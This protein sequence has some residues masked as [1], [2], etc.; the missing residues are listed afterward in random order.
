MHDSASLILKKICLHVFRDC[1]PVYFI[2]DHL[3]K[4]LK[5]DGNFSDLNMSEPEKESHIADVLIFM[6]GLLPLEDQS[7]ELSCIKM[8]SGA[9]VDAFV[10][11]INT[12]Y[13]VIIWDAAKK[14]AFLTQTQQEYNE[15]SLLIEKQKNRIINFSDKKFQK[16]NNIALEDFCRALNLAVFKMNDKG[17]FVPMGK[18]PLWLKKIS[19][20]RDVFP[21]QAYEEDDFSFIGNFINEA[22]SRWAGN[23]FETFHSGIWIEK[24]DNDREFL[25]EATAVNINGKK[26]LVISHDICHP[27]E[28]QSI[29]QKGR[30]LAIDYHH[31]QRS[32]EKLE[33]MRDELELIVKERTKSLEKLNKKLANELKERKKIEKDRE[34][35]A[36]QLRQSQ[37]MEAIGTLAGG[38]AHDFNNILSGIIGFT[39]LCRLDAQ[40]NPDLNQKLAKILTASDRAKELIRQIMVFS[41]TNEYE[42]K[43]LKLRLIVTEALNLV[44]ASI[45]SNIDI[46]KQLKSDGYVLADLTQIHQVIINLCA[47]AWYAMKETGGSLVVELSDIDIKP[48]DLEA[49]YKSMTGRYLLL[50]VKDTGCGIPPD[51]LEKIFDPYFTTKDKGKGTGLGLSVV[52]GIVNRFNGC[53]SVESQLGKGTAF[54]VYIPAFDRPGEGNNNVMDKPMPLGSNETILFVDDESLQTEMAELLLTKLGY[55]VV[56][57]NDGI[58]ALN[59]FLH[60]KDNFDLVITDMMMPKMSGMELAGE[61]IKIRPDMPIIL[62]SGFNDDIPSN[63]EN[64]VGIKQ[65]LMKPIGLKELSHTIRKVLSGTE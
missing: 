40:D 39:E 28:K 2:T 6:E 21:K 53:I 30:E 16:G 26:I 50:T 47:N 58:K 54:K 38:I 3:G 48:G 15:L 18:Q 22:K 62:C 1:A 63:T 27:T 35:V 36:G 24:G 60:E 20:F 34:K 45:P 51:I 37:K 23:N 52:H 17:H 49:E 65:F 5:C 29:I 31:L 59:I 56:T 61:I 9:C 64:Y 13:G 19:F 8:P 12:G 11:K 42:T 7:M 44:R 57:S 4:I 10:F 46:K 14:D 25:F 43:P 32:G 33:L 55:N 41:H